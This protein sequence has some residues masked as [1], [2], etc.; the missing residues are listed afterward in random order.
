MIRVLFFAQLRE[1]LGRPLLELRHD[2]SRDSVAA[3]RRH[4]VEH[5]GEEAQE[6]ARWQQLL[7][8][9]NV[10]CAVNHSVVKARHPLED[11]DEVA[12]YPPVTGG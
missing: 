5:Y 2:P 7:G 3:L 9:A 8:A 11:G 6:A 1:A 4:L 10:I 12:F